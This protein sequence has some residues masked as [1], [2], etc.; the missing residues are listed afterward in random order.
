MGDKRLVCSQQL[1]WETDEMLRNT[2]DLEGRPA[3]LKSTY[4]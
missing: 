2:L 4:S 3:F 1:G